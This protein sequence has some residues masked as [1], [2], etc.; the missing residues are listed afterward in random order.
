M[1]DRLQQ[2]KDWLYS[3]PARLV[4]VFLHFLGVRRASNWAGAVLRCVGPWLPAHRVGQKN[5]AFVFPENTPAQNE[6]IL[7]D[8]WENLGRVTGELPNLDRITFDG[9][10]P[11]LIIENRET[12]DRYLA[13]GQPA[14]LFTGHYGNWELSAFGS[15]F[16]GAPQTIIYRPANNM[17]V[18]RMIQECRRA[19]SGIFVPK[20]AAG[21]KEL[22][23]NIRAGHCPAMLLDQK[24]NTGISVPF[25]GKEAMTAPLGAQLALRFNLPVVPARVTRSGDRF[26]LTFEPPLDFTPSGETDR[27]IYD[28]TLKI[29]Q[30][31]ERWIR[32]EPGYWLWFHR[33]WPKDFYR[34]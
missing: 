6:S 20:G 12:L 32:Q 2:L 24:L 10:D 11:I 19:T 29:N 28:L 31:Y 21:M 4:L 17:Y 14:L 5:I 16:M 1:Y 18:D 26:I 34:S 27:D 8:A 22:I 15:G 23:K 3:W 25:F 33:R 7:K 30:V 13:Q 9:D